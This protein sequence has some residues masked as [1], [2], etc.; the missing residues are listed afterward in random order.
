ILII[1]YTNRKIHNGD[2]YLSLLS[3]LYFA[4]GT[5]FSYVSAYFGT[6]FFALAA[7]STW[8]F[9]L[10]LMRQQTPSLWLILAFSLSGLI[11]GL[12]R[13]EGVILACLML[14]SIIV[15]RG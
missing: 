2:Q 3:G 11:T 7:A 12:I 13:P 1:Y 10:L 15:M 9:S 5:G 4:V 14:L 8:M 6:P